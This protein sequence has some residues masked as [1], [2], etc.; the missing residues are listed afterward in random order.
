MFS[1]GAKGPGPAA[2]KNATG[3]GKVFVS[4]LSAGDD[5]F[6]RRSPHSL[7][8]RKGG[9]GSQVFP[10]ANDLRGGR[11]ETAG[12]V[13]TSSGMSYFK[14]MVVGDTGLGK[15]TLVSLL[16]RG[17]AGSSG[18]AA[19]HSSDA[20][21]A[22]PP[23]TTSV[24]DTRRSV[25]TLDKDGN[26]MTVVFTLVDTPPAFGDAS[27]LKG[28]REPGSPPLSGLAQVREYIHFCLEE[29]ANIVQ[30]QHTG[31][32]RLM[33]D[34]DVRVDCVVYL[35]GPH[36][37]KLADVEAM[38][39]LARVTSVLPVIAKA[40]SMTPA[41]RE[42]F[43][44]ELRDEL[45][46]L[47]IVTVD[48]CAELSLVGE[49]VGS[50]FPFAVVL[51]THL[52]E[53]EP[54]RQYPWGACC[55]TNPAYSDLLLLKE[56]ILSAKGVQW[57]KQRTHECFLSWL[58]ASRLPSPVTSWAGFPGATASL[59]LDAGGG[60]APQPLAGMIPQSSRS[61]LDLR[62]LINGS[63][64]GKDALTPSSS[65]AL[66]VSGANSVSALEAG[67]SSGADGADVS[68]P[69]NASKAKKR[70][71][72][73]R[74]RIWLPRVLAA[75]RMLLVW[76]G[77]TA[78]KTIGILLVML[79]V[80]AL[81]SLLG[82]LFGG[83][84][85]SPP[86][87]PSTDRVD[88]DVGA[89]LRAPGLVQVRYI[90]A[91]S[92]D[93]H[94]LVVENAAWLG[95]LPAPQLINPEG[96][97]PGACTPILATLPAWH[98]ALYQTND[99]V[100]P[101]GGPIRAE[102]TLVAHP[103]GRLLYAV[104]GASTECE[105]RGCADAFSLALPCQPGGPGLLQ[106]VVKQPPATVPP[107]QWFEDAP[108]IDDGEVLV[109]D[110]DA[111]L[112]WLQLH[113]DVLAA[114]TLTHAEVEAFVV[115]GSLRVD[116]QL[117]A[118]LSADVV[119]DFRETGRSIFVSGT[120]Q[121]VNT[122]LAALMYSSGGTSVESD[123]FT[124][125]VT[126]QAQPEAGGADVIA[127]AAD[128]GAGGGGPLLERST[129]LVLPVTVSSRCVAARSRADGAGLARGRM[130]MLVDVTVAC[131]DAQGRPKATGGDAVNVVIRVGDGGGAGGGRR[132][133]KAS[134]PVA[135]GAVDPLLPGVHED[136]ASAGGSGQGGA[137]QGFMQ[138]VRAEDAGDGTY[139]AQF[140][141][142][143][144]DYMVEVQVNG[145]ALEGSPFWHTT[146]P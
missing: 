26:L 83:R 87:R 143:E 46:L 24:D 32:A 30:S 127:A 103:E 135:V 82:G 120:L 117:K 22:E 76:L 41:E 102:H 5:S 125:T 1:W 54:T 115:R 118:E 27:T 9:G 129:Q 61:G 18:P 139:V 137:S 124:V 98:G 73:Q 77:A 15:S 133:K 68:S 114:A 108:A 136:G 131:H 145:D 80:L 84:W 2:E 17:L 51:S 63:K 113:L 146:R 101:E 59:G 35:V 85:H 60:C 4:D 96:L 23:R 7:M 105:S 109:G 44:A 97:P 69:Y 74:V 47:G 99:G 79:T 13:S 134:P 78:V 55:A 126:A 58:Q 138:W 36:R 140:Y 28:E 25:V 42:H 95:I 71:L 119:D 29:H 49:D 91:L 94:I 3:Q 62:D 86:R 70:T 111:P 45:D 11:S 141:R 144:T 107:L 10:E 56:S 110:V 66:V 100:T 14:V 33:S 48:L 116:D 39:A 52:A 142:P 112:G 21:P 72:Q 20:T 130:L 6:T 57:L 93:P 43:R 88:G 123:V 128:V 132:R 31:R 106:L 38:S 34:M 67:G 75:A 92:P 16:S 81:T 19:G 50:R 37:L 53:R 121:A 104:D 122:V 12:V 65:L 40:D 89:L 64:D 90:D 8:R